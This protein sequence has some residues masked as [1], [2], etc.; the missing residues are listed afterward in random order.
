MEINDIKGSYPNG[1]R[2]VVNLQIA[3]GPPTIYTQTPHWTRE[4]A[5]A[6]MNSC[7]K[8]TEICGPHG[9]PSNDAGS[10]IISEYSYCA[11][12]YVTDPNATSITWSFVSKNTG[13]H[14]IWN[15]SGNQFSVSVEDRYPHDWII[16][17]CA[18]SNP[19]GSA[20]VNY[21]FTPDDFGGDCIPFPGFRQTL[22]ARKAISIYPNPSA[23]Q[24]LISLNDANA[25]KGKIKKVLIRDKMGILIF[26]KIFDTNNKNE[27]IN[28]GNPPTGIYT[29]QVFDGNIWSNELFSIN[30]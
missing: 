7:N 22:V 12:G 16:L 13:G 25:G 28:L 23:G 6:Y 29:I 21:K 1:R 11:R 18:S 27:N 15:G 2:A 8:I 20:S 10:S 24:F 4:G 14:F 5:D 30:N 9:R 26:Q 19:C 3:I 17:K